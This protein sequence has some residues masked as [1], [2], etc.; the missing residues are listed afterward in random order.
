[1]HYSTIYSMVH[2]TIRLL[3]YDALLIK[4]EDPNLNRQD[5]GNLRILHSY[6]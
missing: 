5:T 2:D 3:I 4:F 1:M 6:S